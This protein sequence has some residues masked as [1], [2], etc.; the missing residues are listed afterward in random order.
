M[1]DC[2]FCKIIQKKAEAAIIFENEE[3]LAFKDIRPKA[4][5]HVLIIPKEHV[6]DL[7]GMTTAHAPLLGRMM[8]QAASIAKTHNIDES[9]YKVGTNTGNDGGQIIHHFH[10]HL[11]GG[12]PIHVTI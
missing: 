6:N 8:L 11:V 9:G 2:I 4:P 5:V 3:M 1:D 7:N 12:E 10:L